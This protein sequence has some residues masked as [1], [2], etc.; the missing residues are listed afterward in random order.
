MGEGSKVMSRAVL[1]P[2]VGDPYILTAWV[3]Q[4]SKWAGRVNKLYYYLNGL[5]SVND[6]VR[7][8]DI[9]IL[10][11]LGSGFAVTEILEHGQGLATLLAMAVEDHIMFVE[12]DVIIHNADMVDKA[13]R[14]IEAEEYD[15]VGSPRF[16][17]SAGILEASKTKYGLDYTGDGDK[18]PNFWPNFFFASRELLNKTDLDFCSK[19]WKKGELIEPLDFTTEQEEAGDTFVWGSIQLRN[20]VPQ[21]RIF[22]IPQGHS[23][24]TDIDDQKA[25]IGMFDVNTGWIHLGSLS[26]TALQNYLFAGRAMP[27]ANSEIEIRE[28]E[29]RLAWVLTIYEVAKA[30]VEAYGIKTNYESKVNEMIKARALSVKN[31]N[32]LK[33]L[34]RSYYD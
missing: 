25:G 6:Q 30:D 12:E 24:L 27:E 16:S 2:V 32:E 17:C 4:Y 10:S 26:S 20:L 11:G 33:S 18:G 1:L 13:F 7:N 23:G 34:Y 9:S 3:K 15:I 31:I 19:T 28:W 14:K 21:S 5:G 22:E 29:R 8:Y